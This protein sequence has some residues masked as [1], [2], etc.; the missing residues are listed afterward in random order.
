M[1]SQGLQIKTDR[2]EYFKNRKFPLPTTEGYL[3]IPLSNI[4]YCKAVTNYT[5][6]KLKDGKVLISSFTLKY[7]EN[8]FAA[9]GFIRVHKSYL[10]NIAY[11]ERYLRKGILILDDGY[12]I[13]VSKTYRTSLLNKIRSFFTD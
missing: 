6:F 1:T 7:F 5:Q 10:V 11:A 13:E 8:F 2:H 4:I 3:F 12:E 9:Y